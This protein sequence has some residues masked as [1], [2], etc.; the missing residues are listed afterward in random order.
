MSG[1]FFNGQQLIT[2]Q[3]ASMLDDSGMFNKNTSVGNI[4]ALLGRA[5]GGEPF[6]AL[7]FGSADQAK[8]VL[9]GDEVT[10]KAIE[11]AF[12]PSSETTGPSTLI[13]I[14]INPATRAELALGTAIDLVSTDFGRRNNQIKV[15]VESASVKGK[16]LTTAFGN[17]YF[18]K[19]NV[20]RDAMSVRYTGGE[21]TATLAI[22][23]TKAILVAGAT[24][25]EIDL[26]DFPTVQELADRI[27][28]VAGFTANVM[29]GNGLAPTLQALD[30]AAAANCKAADVIVT[31]HLQACIDW[32]NGTGEG[33]V[34]AS[35]KDGATGAPANTAFAYLSGASDGIVTNAEWQKAFE[36]LQQVDA[37]W[38]CPLSPLAAIHAMADTHVAYMSNVSRKKRR[39]ITGGNVGMSDDEALLAAK[40][41]N[42]DRT[43]FIHLGAYDYNP[44][45]KLTLYPAFVVAAAVAGMFAGVAPGVALTNKSMKWRG[46][47]RA[48]RVPTDT[49]VLLAGGVLCLEDGEEGYKV[50]QSLSTW[51]N[52]SNFNRV[53]Q[54]CG[55]ACDF[56]LRNVEEAIDPVRG[57]GGSPRTMAD[58]LSRAETRLN[59]LSVPAPMGPGVLVGD[60]VNPPWRKLTVSLEGDVIRIEYECSPVVPINYALQVAH[61]VPYSG[62]ASA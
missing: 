12:D 61:A 57:K 60:A 3:S 16:K 35:R 13:F 21:A 10:L 1:V 36:V 11:R 45:S 22:T 48:L 38:I 14:R 5:E 59:A 15:K 27:N 4:V 30:T 49:N 58:A 2:P 44:K 56:V 39:A 18:S 19:D 26:I 53:E 31:A 41:L 52:D 50:L 33:F 8:A 51:R 43:S 24:T 40:N 47:E 28:A 55:A 42:S 46:L 34:T 54:S 7:R 62:S 23:S 37:Q 6:K 25:T 32:F 9:K 20:Y 29:D 17:D